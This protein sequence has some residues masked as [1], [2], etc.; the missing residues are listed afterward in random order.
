MEV[1]NGYALEP[2]TR[3]L[4]DFFDGRGVAPSERSKTVVLRTLSRSLFSAPSEA[5]FAVRKG[6]HFTTRLFL[7]VPL[8]HDLLARISF[9]IKA[10]AFDPPVTR[11]PCA[12]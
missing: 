5:G 3:A 11:G 10:I 1:P 4:G 2:S 7:A 9:R 6:V 12:P 8:F